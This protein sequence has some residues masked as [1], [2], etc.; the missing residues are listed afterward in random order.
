VAEI[1]LSDPARAKQAG[2]EVWEDGSGG[3]NCVLQPGLGPVRTGVSEW[4]RARL[5]T[6]RGR[7]DGTGGP[8]RGAGLAGGTDRATPVG[9]DPARLP[10][11][12]LDV[13]DGA[14]TLEIVSCDSTPRADD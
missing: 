6:D 12:A 1:P 11:P 9:F 2:G 10:P 8:D 14:D 3:G 13:G 5:T 7:A 4:G